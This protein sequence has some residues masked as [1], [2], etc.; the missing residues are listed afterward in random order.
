VLKKGSGK[1]ASGT[2]SMYSDTII[3]QDKFI[4]NRG[5]IYT[6]YDRRNVPHD[7]NFVQDKVSKSFQGVVRGF[8]GD[9]ETWKL[10]SCLYGTIKLV[11]YNIDK[12][13]KRTYILDSEDII[14]KSVLVPPR[15]L[16]AHQCLSTSCI[17][18]YKWSEYYTNPENQWSVCYNDL[19]I[20]PCWDPR[21]PPIV[22][23]RD[24]N[25]LTLKELK[26]HVNSTTT[27]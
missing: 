1:Q 27:N 26:N 19:D 9:D 23:E 17:F 3:V 7:I 6:V 14:N 15:T 20:D 11:T 5:S 24:K 22:S 12:D 21:Y 8:H 13:V 25:S 2:K 16:N 10:I 4:E 18:H